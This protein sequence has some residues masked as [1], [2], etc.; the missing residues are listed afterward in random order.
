[1]KGA[2]ASNWPVN[3]QLPAGV[4]VSIRTPVVALKTFMN[5][6]VV[7]LDVGRGSRFELELA[8]QELGFGDG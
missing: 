3:F 2:A 4:I 5:A 1:V 6:V 8:D 7:W